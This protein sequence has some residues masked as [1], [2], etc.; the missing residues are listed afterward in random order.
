MST[1]RNV[2]Q[3]KYS[4]TFTCKLQTT[5]R[6]SH[7]TA[8]ISCPWHCPWFK[9]IHAYTC[10]LYDSKIGSYIHLMIWVD[11]IW[12][13]WLQSW[14]FEVYWQLLG[15]ATDRSDKAW[16]M[17]ADHLL[18]DGCFKL[19]QERIDCI[20][21]KILSSCIFTIFYYYLLYLIIIYFFYD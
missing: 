17:C 5:W 4:C 13:C 1:W 15:L 19:F 9:T 3:N 2:P 21:L 11:F 18:A 20:P 6:H 7:W 10:C 8:P 16:P 14:L 12:A